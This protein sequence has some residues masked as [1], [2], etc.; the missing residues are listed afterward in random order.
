VPA[1]QHQQ[2]PRVE[3]VVRSSLPILTT[4]RLQSMQPAS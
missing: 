4:F 2:Y 3:I 1:V